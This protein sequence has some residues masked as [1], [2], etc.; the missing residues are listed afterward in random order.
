MGDKG[1]SVSRFASR[2]AAEAARPRVAA[3][4]AMISHL[5]IWSFGLGWR[6]KRLPGRLAYTRG[7]YVIKRLKANQP[8]HAL[9]ASESHTFLLHTRF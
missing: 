9:P 3:R 8:V 6:K 2:G 5:G 7:A 1:G 4:Q